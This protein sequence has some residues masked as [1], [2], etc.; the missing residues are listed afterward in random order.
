[1]SNVP[2]CVGWK[3]IVKPKEGKTET[4]GGIDI[5]ETVAAQSHLV[6][7]GEIIDMGEAAFKTRT[8]GGL[9]MNEWKVRPQV[10]DH[11]IFSP[12]SG[13]RIRRSGEVW[14]ILLMNDTDIHA[15]VDDPDD[16]YS[17]LDV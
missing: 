17:Y 14:P 10:G 2:M 13:L 16:Y 12:Y 6:Y 11:V 4:A 5:S 15:I 1:M 9:D 3:V 8:A 7:L